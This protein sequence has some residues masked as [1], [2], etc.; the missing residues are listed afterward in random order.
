MGNRTISETVPELNTSEIAYIFSTLLGY[1]N[2]KTPIEYVLL[3]F[4]EVPSGI[5]PL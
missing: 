5:E 2:A 3:G 4:S 1:K